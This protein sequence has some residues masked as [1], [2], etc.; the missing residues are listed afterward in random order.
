MIRS[1]LSKIQLVDRVQ[2][3]TQLCAGKK[4]LHLGA[5]DA[6]ITEDSVRH[7]RLLHR[8]LAKVANHIIGLDM[9]A[10]MIDF[11]SSHYGINSIKLGNIEKLEDYPNEDFDVI[12][13][14][15][16]LE[17]LNNPGDALKCIYQV[18]NINSKLV[19][20]VPNT[21]SLKGF[22]RAIANYEL[23]HPDHV[24]YHSPHTL[25]ILLKRHGFFVDH[26]FSYINGGTG[27]LASVANLLLRFHPQLSEGIGVICSI[28][29][30]L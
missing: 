2:Y 19:I 22:I 25:K 23:I 5:A 1:D 4:V 11:L 12:V 3:L 8:H 24:L 18:S 21:Y 29:N 30:T 28:K 27:I 16:I 9:D 10:S 15:E 7:D 17:H 14:G 13:A 20:T 26:Y 6:P